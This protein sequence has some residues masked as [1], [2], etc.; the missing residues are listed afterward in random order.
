MHTR[1]NG[2]HT[3]C[4]AGLLATTLAASAA[5]YPLA[6]PPPVVTRTEPE[7]GTLELNTTYQILT[8]CC[9]ILKMA[10][11][12]RRLASSAMTAC[13]NGSNQRWKEGYFEVTTRVSLTR[14][15][16]MWYYVLRGHG[17]RFSVSV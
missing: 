3:A 11:S 5:V 8:R 17:E 7:C 1:Q 15:C 13:N 9:E 12:S 16:G 2:T 10:K 4:L 14:G 6:T